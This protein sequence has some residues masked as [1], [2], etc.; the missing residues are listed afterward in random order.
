MEAE[1][2]K[3]DEPEPPVMLVED[4]LQLRLVEFV[5]TA[6]VTALVKPLTGITV[7]VEVPDTLVLT[8]TVVGLAVMLKFGTAVTW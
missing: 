4:R 5:V 1:H 7:K 6:R 3:V 2:D 8:E